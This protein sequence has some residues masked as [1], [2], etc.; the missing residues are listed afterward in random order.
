ML[1]LIKN[2][3]RVSNTWLASFIF[4]LEIT[5]EC[6]SDVCA[7]VCA[8]HVHNPMLK[9]AINRKKKIRHWNDLKWKKNYFIMECFVAF[10][11]YYR[12]YVHFLF[13][14]WERNFIFFSYNAW[15]RLR[16]KNIIVQ[17]IKCFK[18]N[19]RTQKVNFLCLANDFIRNKCFYPELSS[20]TNENQQMFRFY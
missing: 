14:S 11:R 12:F 1:I 4:F 8:H 15:H 18:V 10:F 7:N 13:L 5:V 20:N 3:H 6:K 9:I 16:D 2:H 19:S 17:S